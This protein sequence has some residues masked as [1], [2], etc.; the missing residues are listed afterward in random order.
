M[1]PAAV[2][3]RIIGRRV[4]VEGQDAG[5]VTGVLVEAMGSPI[6]LEVTDA[7]LVRRFLPLVAAHT[8]S[9]IVK[10]ASALLLVDSCDAYVDRGAV[11]CR[12]AACFSE[13][14]RARGDVSHSVA[15]GTATA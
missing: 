3:G 15:A 6:G 10:V 1:T 12:D 8:G 11:L 14:A 2:D 4:A 13:L 7:A 9:G 5:H